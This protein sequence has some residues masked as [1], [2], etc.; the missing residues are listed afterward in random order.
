MRPLSLLPLLLPCLSLPP[1]PPP[2][3]PSSPLH[4]PSLLLPSS[5]SRA[6]SLLLPLYA[7]DPSLPSLSPLLLRALE[8]AHEEEP[9]ELSALGLASFLLDQERVDEAL[10]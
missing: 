7:A 1:P 8:A 10:P 2:F 5:P 3:L 9:T 6:L 4:I